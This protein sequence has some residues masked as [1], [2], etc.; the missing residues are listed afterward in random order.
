MRTCTVCNE[1]Y[2]HPEAWFAKDH[3]TLRTVCNR[4]RRTAGRVVLCSTATTLGNL[5]KRQRELA[6]SLHKLGFEVYF[7]SPGSELA[8]RYKRPHLKR[9]LSRLEPYDAY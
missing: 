3:N 7:A 9:P 2:S 4:C 5:S 1:T 6:A 8:W